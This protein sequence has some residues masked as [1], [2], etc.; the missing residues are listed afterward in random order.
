[1]TGAEIRGRRIIAN[2]PEQVGFKREVRSNHY[3]KQE[4]DFQLK[5]IS[6]QLNNSNLS[7]ADVLWEMLPHMKAAGLDN[8]L[9]EF[10]AGYAKRLRPDTNWELRAQIS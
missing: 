6:T 8:S 5:D 7:E 1:M 3:F 9:F 2:Q 10:I 4:I